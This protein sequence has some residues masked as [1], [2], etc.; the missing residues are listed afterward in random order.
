MKRL[1]VKVQSSKL[2]FTLIE[3]LISIFIITIFL[4]ISFAG[5]ASLNQRQTLIAGGQNLKNILRDAQNRAINPELDCTKCNCEAGANIGFSGWYVDFTSQKI[6]AK[7]D[8]NQFGDKP[9]G[10]SSDIGVTPKV[11]PVG[12]ALIFKN[13]PPSVSSDAVVCVA[14]SNLESTYYVIR[15]KSTGAISD[16]GGLVGTCP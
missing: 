1:K 10:L 14:H 9:F 16:D 6:Y 12:S 15:I 5:Y 3:L 11:T 7:C 4:G 8:A 2:G 13:N